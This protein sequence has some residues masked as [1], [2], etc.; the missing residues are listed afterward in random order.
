MRGSQM[1][2]NPSDA[3]GIGITNG[4][5]VGGYRRPDTYVRAS[6]CVSYSEFVDNADA[7]VGEWHRVGDAGILADGSRVATDATIFTPAPKYGRNRK[8]Y[9]GVAEDSADIVSLARDQAMRDMA[10]M[11]E[12][13]TVHSEQ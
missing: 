2:I 7:P 13:G 12:M 11:A 9:E 6:E 5:K 3:R 10:L 1:D 4:T 8:G